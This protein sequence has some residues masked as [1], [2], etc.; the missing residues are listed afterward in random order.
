[1]DTDTN[2]SLVIGTFRAKVDNDFITGS[3]SAMTTSA[4]LEEVELLCDQCP[5][6]RLFEQNVGHI[7][8][9]IFLSLDYESLR[10]CRSV[11]RYWSAFLTSDTLQ[12]SDHFSFNQ[13]CD[14]REI[15]RRGISNKIPTDDSEES[16]ED[17]HVSNWITDGEEVVYV[18][19]DSKER[20]YLHFITTDGLDK[21]INLTE[22]VNEMYLLKRRF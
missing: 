8:E 10:N 22:N 11:Y 5:F 17:N 13:W 2:E 1:M 15:T 3:L 16:D 21:S 12:R 18:M 6:N 19:H 9:M 4:T 7:L 14:E 20:N